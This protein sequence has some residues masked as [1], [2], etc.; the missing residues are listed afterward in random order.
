MAID[1]IKSGGFDA[2]TDFSSYRSVARSKGMDAAEFDQQAKETGRHIKAAGRNC[3]S[4]FAR[5]R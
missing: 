1:T 2:V 3:M 4:R 5:R